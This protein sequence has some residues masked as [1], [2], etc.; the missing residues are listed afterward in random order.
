MKTPED[1]HQAIVAY[2][3]AATLCRRFPGMRSLRRLEDR[4]NTLTEVLVKYRAMVSAVGDGSPRIIVL[5]GYQDEAYAARVS[6]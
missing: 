1:L 6:Q 2:N 3:E 4:T 5:T